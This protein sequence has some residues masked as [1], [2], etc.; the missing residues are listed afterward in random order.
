[1]S[2][3]KKIIKT[4][5][6]RYLYHGSS[7]N[8]L[9]S[10]LSEGLNNEHSSVYDETYHNEKG[11]RSLESYGGVYLTD[12]LR[13]ALMAGS[14]ASEKNKVDTDTSVIA[15]IQIEDTSPSVLLD[16]D[17]LSDPHHSISEVTGMNPVG[18]T[19]WVINGF[20][21]I[22]NAVDSY[23]QN[24][25]SERTQITDNRF[26]Q[27]IRPYVYNLLKTYA[28]QKLAIAINNED[29][30][31][32]QL[33]NSYPELAGLIG[34][35]F[36]EKANIPDI[37]TAVQ[38]YRNANALFMQKAKRLTEFMN[39]NFQNNMRATEPLSYR[40]KN[41]IVLI[42]TYTRLPYNSTEGEY[43]GYNYIIK[44]LYMSNDNVINKYI[45]DI[46]TKYS[47]RFLMT[48]NDT[49]LYDNKRE[50]KYELV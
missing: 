39:S 40:G 30:G 29:W 25:S 43:A 37:S 16:E 18:L 3:Y 32:S 6:I 33:K 27:G 36:P 23:L 24:L 49:V 2:W 42:S 31:T 28:I 45:S 9:E 10:I 7:V 5:S 1:M 35:G 21:N 41:R 14:T 4:A 48:Y 17:L 22:E 47:N 38:N 8:N 11:E 50:K 26:L 44:I 46:K 19:E 20:P 15:I 12:N 13:T 34:Y